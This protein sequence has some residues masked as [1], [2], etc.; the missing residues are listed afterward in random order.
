M[1]KKRI[2]I[3]LL[4]LLLILSIFISGCAAAT[5]SD[6]APLAPEY[7]DGYPGSATPEDMDL[8]P[9]EPNP[10]SPADPTLPRKVI[11][12]ADMTVVSTDPVKTKSDIESKAS[13]LGG[14]V[15]DFSQQTNSYIY[16]QMTVEVPGDKL[17]VFLRQIGD[18]GVK[19]ERQS[20]SSEDVT[21]SYY[22]TETRPA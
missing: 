22:D 4:S 10:V 13:S 7:S 12:N 16:I 5:K 14:F 15:S 18:S 11:K 8:P 3:L 1:K 20:V 21:D 9:I 17:E 6:R 19:V 2:L